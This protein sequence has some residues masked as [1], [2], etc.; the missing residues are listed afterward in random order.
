MT[1]NKLL[2]NQIARYC[3]PGTCNPESRSKDSN[4]ELDRLLSA[5]FRER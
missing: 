1:K 4:H 2:A 5:V 3:M